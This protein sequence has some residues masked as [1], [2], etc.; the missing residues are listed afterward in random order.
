MVNKRWAAGGRAMTGTEALAR[1]DELNSRSV[2][3]CPLCSR[4][5][6]GTGQLH[7]ECAARVDRC[8][9]CGRDLSSC[10]CYPELG[11]A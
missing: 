10:R 2:G 8:H 9:R 6:D 1:L 11:A 7:A 4:R 3:A 5:I